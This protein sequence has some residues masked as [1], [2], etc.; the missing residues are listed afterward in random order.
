[1]INTEKKEYIYK[2]YFE[3]EPKIIY[4]GKTN[5]PK[6]R[7]YQH[8]YLTNKN[9]DSK[10]YNWLRKKIKT[11]PIQFII[12]KESN[13]SEYDEIKLIEHHKKNGYI[14][15]NSTNGGEGIKA[16]FKHTNNFGIKQ[17]KYNLAQ[18][19]WK[20]SSNPFFE[21]TGDKNHKSIKCYKYDLDGNYICKYDSINLAGKE[22]NK[23]GNR[24]ISRACNTF[25]IAYGFQWRTIKYNMLPKIKYKRKLLT[26]SEIE[27]I[28]I[29]Y[30]NGLSMNKL[31][32]KFKVSRHQIKNKL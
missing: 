2:I 19:K 21:K 24:L 20:G 16:G 10:L 30:N 18:N 13:N 22:L 26:Q 32:Q 27:E 1:M 6:L 11:E 23:N 25:E 31:S 28:K 8:L 17:R 3:S 14:L 4:I 7:K 5:N 29:L 9:K 12:L 15:K